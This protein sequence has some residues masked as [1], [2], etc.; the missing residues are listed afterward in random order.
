MF[1][2]KLFAFSLAALLALAPFTAFAQAAS[3]PIRVIMDE[4]E[5]SFD[6]QPRIVNDRT[7][8]PLRGVFEAMGATVL[9]NAETKTVTALRL[10]T[11]V[12]LVIGSKNAKVDKK[13]RQLEVAAQIFNDRTFVPLRFISESMGAKVDWNGASRTVTIT[14][15]KAHWSDPG[16]QMS[17]GLL[18]NS[19][20]VDME[21]GDKMKFDPETFIQINDSWQSKPDGLFYSYSETA[22]GERNIIQMFL[23]GAHL[24]D[25][26]M[27]FDPDTRILTDYLFETVLT[28][29]SIAGD[30]AKAEANASAIKTSNKSTD[31]YTGTLQKGRFY[32][33]GQ[34]VWN[35]YFYVDL[36][37]EQYEKLLNSYKEMDFIAPPSSVAE[38]IKTASDFSQVNP[39]EIQV[40][41][42]K[43]D[44]TSFEGKDIRF[45]GS[46]FDAHTAHHVRYIVFDIESITNQ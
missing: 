1:I 41:D 42:A 28:R 37:K 8:V 34:G 22:E 21:T 6:A 14:T 24:K 19:E 3:S 39:N 43:Q 29:W 35:D 32:L 15:D 38:L 12:K 40:Y 11:V 30:Q 25:H 46:Y 20:W 13:D 10:D 36:G 31:S 16:D 5:L 4:R 45:S 27:E 44:L 18:F 9:W 23:D 33:D 26:W 2:K 17:F 7:L